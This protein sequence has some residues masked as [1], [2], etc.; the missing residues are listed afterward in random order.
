MKKVILTAFLFLVLLGCKGGTSKAP[1]IDLQSPFIGGTNGLQ[2]SFQDLRK[3]VFDA[4][5]DPFDIV[6]RLENKG[7]TLVPKDKVRVKISGINPVE[8]S[9]S[10]AD[11]TRNPSDDVIENRKTPQG[12]TITG[13]PAFAEFLG[14]NHKNIIEGASIPYTIKAEVCYLYRTKALSKLCFRENLLTPES[15]GICEINA[16]KPVHNSGAPVQITNLKESTRNKDRI[17]FT[18]DVRNAGS[19][20]VF[21]RSKNCDKSVRQNENKVYVKVDTGM[22]GLTCTGL[23][24][25]GTSAEGYVTLYNGF[26]TISCTQPVSTNTD[27]EQIINIEASYDYE[28][29]IQTQITVKKS[30]E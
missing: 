28:Q 12:N 18:F 29:S 1:A 22:S 30:G 25:S 26:K 19:G 7:E 3:E 6:V 5:S 16:D 20:N 15:G 9:K 23:D 13:P 21:E 17:G 14:L 11:L 24:T 8:F 4:G 10:E 2:L 27:F